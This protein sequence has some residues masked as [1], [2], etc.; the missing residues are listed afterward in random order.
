MNDDWNEPKSFPLSV[1]MT[2]DG[3]IVERADIGESGY[4]E[5]VEYTLQIHYSAGR[6]FVAYYGED[7]TWLSDFDIS[8]AAI[9]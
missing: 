1:D 2:P 9:I 7:D 4:I 6:A 8:M 5:N 3:D